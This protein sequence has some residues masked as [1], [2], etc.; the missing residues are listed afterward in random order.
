MPC[1]D[2]WNKKNKVI[3]L[4]DIDRELAKQHED[5]GDMITNP[6][7]LTEF[8][9]AIDLRDRLRGLI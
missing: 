2:D 7:K 4:D 5:I 3:S 9:G 8:K 1:G 6:T